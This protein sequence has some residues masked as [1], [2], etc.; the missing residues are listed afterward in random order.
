VKSKKYFLIFSSILF[1][2]V[3]LIFSYA[4]DLPQQPSPAES[5]VGVDAPPYIEESL[6]SSEN[7]TLDFKGGGY[8]QCP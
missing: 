2:S 3:S 1:L 6:S 4:E 5:K 8:T 7:V